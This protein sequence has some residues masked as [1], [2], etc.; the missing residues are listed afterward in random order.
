[1]E[2]NASQQAD[3][4]SPSSAANIASSAFGTPWYLANIVPPENSPQDAPKKSSDQNP[5]TAL[6][7]PAASPA[8]AS[9]AS[10]TTAPQT[11]QAPLQAAPVAGANNPGGRPLT[12][13]Q[14]ALL[15]ERNDNG[16]VA[17]VAPAA[18]SPSKPIE[19]SPEQ[20]ILLLQSVGSAPKAP[21]T[22]QPLVNQQLGNQISANPA[23]AIVSSPAALATPV[24]P[25]DNLTPQSV[26]SN[27]VT[28]SAANAVGTTPVAPG[29][30]LHSGGLKPAGELASPPNGVFAQRMKYGLDKYLAN[31]MPLNNQPPRL[32]VIQ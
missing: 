23:P 8:V 32:D 17:A 30:I 7:G 6:A 19:L 31:P 20:E 25:A 2:D 15:N 16:N 27:S 5:T 14:Q 11:R 3:S 28:D 9:A 12:P 21:D 29:P 24:A 4:S 13:A 22:F 26:E 1:A 10:A 18:G